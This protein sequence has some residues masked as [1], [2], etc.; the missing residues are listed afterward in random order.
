[1]EIVPVETVEKIF[2]K[3]WNMSEAQAVRMSFKL[4]NEQP[5]LVAYMTAVDKNILNQAEREMLFYLGTVVWQIISNV[6]KPLPAVS[7]ERLLELEKANNDFAIS[8]RT[9]N[10]LVFIEVVKK[11]L[12]EIRQQPIMLY[13]IAT[14]MDEDSTE[15]EIRNESL[16]F[17]LINLKTIIEGFDQ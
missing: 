15:N 14:L 6:R 5:E 17:I 9:T 12:Q 13:V 1:M 16:G 2:E 4:A 3:M 7:L 11:I 8:L 10:T